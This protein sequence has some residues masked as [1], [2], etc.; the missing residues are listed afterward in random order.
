MKIIKSIILN[1]ENNI[2]NQNKVEKTWLKE[3]KLEE[4]ELTPYLIH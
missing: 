2:I 4:P 3:D 1:I